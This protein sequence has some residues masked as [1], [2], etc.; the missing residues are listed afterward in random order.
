MMFP[1]FWNET[2]AAALGN[3]LWQS[4]E[5][6]GI[7]WLLALGL[8]NN[9]ARTRYWVWMIASVKFLIPFSLLIAA[10]EWLRS[11]FATP[12]QKPA[13]AAVMEQ[14][15]L[16]FPQTASPAAVAYSGV[17]P[18]AA[19]QP[20]NLL[21]QILL[22]V[23]LCGFLLVSFSWVRGWLRIWASVRASSRMPLQADVPVLSSPLS[24]E[25][26]IFGIVRPVLLLPEGIN[27][28]LTTAQLGTIIAHEMCHLRRRDNLTAAIHMVVEALFW[29][30][31][32]VWW[33][34]T[35][36]LEEREQACDEAVLQ[37]GSEADL[38]A[39]SILNVCKFCIESPLACVAG[40][41]GS[42]LKRRI[43]RIMTER[44]AR[45]LNL[46]RKLLLALAATVAVS[47]PVVFG[48]VHI[49]LTDAQA[50][51]GNP[52]RGLAGTWQGTL[53]TGLDLRAVIKISKA[54]GG[55]YNA[56]IYA[57]D[58]I[59][60]SI[61]VSKIALDGATVRFSVA[62][63][64]GAFEGKL[65]SDGTSIT[66]N[67]SQYSFT[68]PLTLKRA[69]PETAW[70]IPVRP[71]PMAANADPSFVT[72]TIQPSKPDTPSRAVTTQMGRMAASN[73]TLSDLISLAYEINPKQIIG[74]PDWL[75][76]ERFDIDAKYREGG[77]PNESQLR[78][79]VRK[80]LAGSFHLSLHRET[81]ELAV[82]A[83]S[84]AGKAPKLNRSAASPSQA[85]DLLLQAVGKLKVGNG[86]MA[87]FVKVMQLGVLDRPVLDRTG[88]EGRYDFTLNWSPDG[89]QFPGLGV[90]IPHPTD[91]THAPPPLSAAIQEQLGLKLEMVR[92]PVE[93]LVIDRVEKPSAEN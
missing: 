31:P 91:G 43:V 46:G 93:A 75:D 61:P 12:I 56:V 24:M 4:T 83:L 30:H 42:D 64:D 53:H 81:R 50:S 5:V 68:H 72:T 10:G 33:I 23:W 63:F 39:E 82:Y 74:A 57:I 89:S 78:G 8:R 59:A 87:D 19:S 15:A 27:D 28:R 60:S 3:H 90:T 84:T 34:K 88:I 40:V 48:L 54:E 52:A 18:A 32:A 25:P 21:P 66:G 51:T 22:A 67:W 35:R 85:P 29:F 2:S 7:A 44:M 9:H 11:T 79:M 58:Q 76:T 26:G 62:D 37:S 16:P 73:L 77:V 20:G 65:S 17:A 36:L 92:A 38:Y 14:I 70:E 49:K 47:V 13:L 71:P 69:T 6:T 86:S 45:N 55:G 41:T 80:M 1:A